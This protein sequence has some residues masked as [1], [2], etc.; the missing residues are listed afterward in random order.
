MKTLLFV[1]LA[2]FFCA[3]LSTAQIE[4]LNPT[5]GPPGPTGPP[6]TF[7]ISASGFTP[8]GDSARLVPLYGMILGQSGHTIT[9]KVDTS[10]I[11]YKTWVTTNFLGIHATAD[12][13]IF[14]RTSAITSKV[15]VSDSNTVY[16]TPTQLAATQVSR[17]AVIKWTAVSTTPDSQYVIKLPAGGKIDSIYAFQLGASAM[18]IQCER[19]TGGTVVD[20]LSSSYSV[21]TSNAKATGLQNNT[22][23][24]N[25]EAWAVIKTVT[26][27]T[28]QV[29]ITFFFHAQE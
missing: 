1:L 17:V 28:T 24:A 7:L 10:V 3:A 14:V 20:L 8:F 13:A 16:V 21:R 22:L 26:G 27:T 29:N 4:P 19:N 15:N 23:A 11:A 12:S 6:G 25:A 5:M 18:T 9:L 2:I